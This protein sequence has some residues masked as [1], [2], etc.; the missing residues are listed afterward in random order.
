ME[1]HLFFTNGFS[2]HS[3][4]EGFHEASK[5]SLMSI[6]QKTSPS[7]VSGPLVFSPSS[8]WLVLVTKYSVVH[9]AVDLVIVV[10]YS[11]I[12]RCLDR[13]CR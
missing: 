11:S 3:H 12:S 13:S 8:S 6:K 7:G 1:T 9:V 2:C 10:I 4:S 5:S